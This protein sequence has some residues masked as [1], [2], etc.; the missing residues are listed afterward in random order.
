MKMR[1]AI[2]FFSLAVILAAC[3]TYGGPR[4]DTRSRAYPPPN[5]VQGTPG[6]SDMAS[7]SQAETA[8]SDEKAGEVT[9]PASTPSGESAAKPVLPS[10]KGRLPTGLLAPPSQARQEKSPFPEKDKQR[11]VL[12]FDKADA[13]EVTSQIFGD[14]LKLNYVLDPTVQGRISLYIEGE[15]TRDE[16]FQMITR[17]YAAN[18]ISITPRKGIYSIQPAQK[19][20]SSSLPIADSITL[21]EGKNGSKPAI[22]IYRLRFLDVKQA[23][24][25]VRFFLTP[26]RPITSDTLTNSVIFVEDTD[27]ARTM[28]DVLKALDVNILQEVSMEIIPVQAIS[29]QEA[30]QSMETLMNK[31]NVFKDSTIKNGLAFIPLL[32]F[33][34]VLVLAQNP[35]LMKTAKYWLTALDVHSKETGEQ[36]YVYFVQNG[37][38]RDIADILTSVYGISGQTSGTRPQQQIVQSS[39]RTGTFG[40][41]GFGSSGSTFGSSSG[42]S[43]GSSSTMGSSSSLGS[44]S[45]STGTP[46]GGTGSSFGRGG[47][48]TTQQR[49]TAAGGV[50]RA[51][52]TLTGEVVII[53]DEVN[54]A[55]VIRANAADYAKIKKTM[56]TLDIIPRAVLIDVTVAEVRLTK[57]LQYG[58]NWF[59]QNIGIFGHQGQ[60]DASSGGGSIQP[61]KTSGSTDSVNVKNP[62]TTFASPSTIASAAG[63][64]FF[65]GSVNQ[66]I[67][68]LL[69]LLA[70]K[71]DVNVLSNPTLLATD[72]KEASIT[73]GGRTP[74]PVGSAIG[75]TSDAVVSSIQYE[76]TGVILNVIPHINAGGLV[77]MELEQTIRDVDKQ[78]VT[79]GNN[80]TAP[81]FSERNIKT[82]VLA[83]NGS[84]IVIGG[85]ILNNLKKNKSGLPVLQD[86]PVLGPLFTTS[87]DNTANRTELIIALT[88]HVV[89]HRES[90]VT[91]EFL[92][93]L[94]QLK[95]QVSQ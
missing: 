24:N 22:V 9:K 83:Q 45:G 88:P 31:L 76:E 37:L 6:A 47:I 54:N 72:N 95:R 25:T 42:G 34:G 73:V 57:E 61:G 12:N 17:A 32:N 75:T 62:V 30:V 94:M 38:A 81:S 8:G 19:S 66:K 74:V 86:I 65:W 2:L 58:V 29:P 46:L 44:S 26:G 16:L 18:N 11:V 69:Q 40:S 49:R 5:P 33:G 67:S 3:S 53:A 80:S 56:E 71:T 82:T 36:I 93:K 77:R 14:Y 50:P 1:Q 41:R 63:P 23:I 59:F 52:Q 68:T 39:Q 51:G 55:V 27:N 15:F 79:V 20:A 92:D 90:T 78:A 85:I 64:T 89:E 7:T 87:A 35:E 13:A 48:S 28:V 43:F 84:T 70:T 10:L 60:F 4:Q 21:Q 91:R